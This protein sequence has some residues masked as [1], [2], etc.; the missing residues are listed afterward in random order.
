MAMRFSQKVKK[1]LDH[2]AIYR[3]KTRAKSLD[4][5]RVDALLAVSSTR[6]ASHLTPIHIISQLHEKEIHFTICLL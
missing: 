4:Q 6:S 5:K 2:T 1:T 3:V